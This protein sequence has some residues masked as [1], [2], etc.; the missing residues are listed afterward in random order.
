[1][2]K[3]LMLSAALAAF[4]FAPAVA[5]DGDA[6]DG[7]AALPAA[8]EAAVSSMDTSKTTGGSGMS[9]M[10]NSMDGMMSGGDMSGSMGAVE[11]ANM[12]AMMVMQAPM[13]KAMTIKDADLAFNCGMIAHHRGAIAM[14]KVEL[15]MGKDETSKTLAR[16]I[17]DAQEKEIEQITAW[18]EKN[19]K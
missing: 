8:C 17:I 5:Q 15:E 10:M 11:K 4:P 19:G 2:R 1:M 3:I 13:M 18:L 16:T 9:K 14:A 6:T 7:Q 12:Q